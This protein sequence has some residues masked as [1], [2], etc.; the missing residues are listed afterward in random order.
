MSQANSNANDNNDLHR[1]QNVIANGSNLKPQE[2]VSISSLY[3]K[4]NNEFT[5][6]FPNNQDCLDMVYHIYLALR[7]KDYG[8]WHYYQGFREYSPIPDNCRTI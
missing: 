3:D 7:S 4:E 2:I 8:Q 5:A 6:L 1:H